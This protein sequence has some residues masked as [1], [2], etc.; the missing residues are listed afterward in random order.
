MSKNS[1][2]PSRSIL[3]DCEDH[4]DSH[5][6]VMN[7]N[8]QAIQSAELPDSIRKAVATLAAKME[9]YVSERKVQLQSL[10]G[11]CELRI[12]SLLED[13]IRGRLEKYEDMFDP[14]IAPEA[15][16][17]VQVDVCPVEPCEHWRT[18]DELDIN[19]FIHFPKNRAD[20]TPTTTY[21]AMYILDDIGVSVETTETNSNST[22]LEVHCHSRC[23]T[24]DHVFAQECELTAM[25][26][27]FIASFDNLNK[28]Q[29]PTSG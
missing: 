5:I 14:Y 26:T 13:E 4:I 23:R 7:K 11:N 20:G 21:C 12:E 1:N 24:V 2:F 17:S 25:W 8:I 18:A 15:R 29:T 3:D 28:Q 27:Q 19:M 16:F 9:P 10:K 6:R 22:H